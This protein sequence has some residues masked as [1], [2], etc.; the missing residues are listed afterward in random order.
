MVSPDAVTEVTRWAA[1]ALPECGFELGFHPKTMATLK[2]IAH[3]LINSQHERV[4]ENP[5]R[6]RAR[7]ATSTGFL[8]VSASL[9]PR[10]ASS[11]A[12]FRDGVRHGLNSGVQNSGIDIWT[13]LTH[14][15]WV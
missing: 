8:V 12:G 4:V 14:K 6:W 1:I 10:A 15:P 5:L 2:D 9:A 11:R 13:F 7:A 3:A